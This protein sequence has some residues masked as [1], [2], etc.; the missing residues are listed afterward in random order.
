MSD[1]RVTH[2]GG[3]TVLLEIGE[4]RLLTDP[5][6]D[7]P[8]AYQLPHVMLEKL[9]GPALAAEAIGEVDA[10]L[11]SHAHE[12]NSTAGESCCRAPRPSSPRS[13]ARSDWVAAPRARGLGKTCLGADGRPAVQ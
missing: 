1:V 9:S 13:P 6:F 2:I 8:G 12:D 4:W 10:V 5:T 3:P 7:A 11:L